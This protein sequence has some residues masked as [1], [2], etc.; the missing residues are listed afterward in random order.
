MTKTFD[1]LELLYGYYR[2]SQEIQLLDTYRGMPISNPAQVLSVSD[3]NVLVSVHQNQTVCLELQH[4]TYINL[5][6]PLTV[7][8]VVCAG[9]IDTRLYNLTDINIAENKLGNREILRVN[10]K[11]PLPVVLTKNG[12]SN[13]KIIAELI[14]LSVVGIGVYGLSISL[15]EIWEFRAGS[16]INVRLILPENDQEPMASQELEV[17]GSIVNIVP[18]DQEERIRLGIKITPDAETRSMITTYVSKR[19]VEIIAEIRLLY[20]TLVRLSRK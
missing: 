4:R 3:Q 19:Q 11:I 2:T 7:E 13:R 20:K 17:A 18:R 8:A 10:P 14:D 5:D 1:I 9:N 16:K 12:S 6:L 15:A